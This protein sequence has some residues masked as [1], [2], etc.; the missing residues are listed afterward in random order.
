MLGSNEI[1]LENCPG[2]M[3]SALSPFIPRV[4]FQDGASGTHR[5]TSTERYKTHCTQ[6]LGRVW[7]GGRLGA[8]REGLLL[9]GGAGRELYRQGD[10]SKEGAPASSGRL[11]QAPSLGIRQAEPDRP[12]WRTDQE[13][14][15]ATPA[16]LNRE[17]GPCQGSPA[18]SPGL[19]EG[20]Q[21]CAVWP[22]P[23]KSL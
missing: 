14:C 13:N 19:G 22:W 15:P 12:T 2:S 10:G 9:K 1:M 18:K 16:P 11:H 17:G 8:S 4:K 7:P 23:V 3:E 21:G 5:M 20:S 6:G